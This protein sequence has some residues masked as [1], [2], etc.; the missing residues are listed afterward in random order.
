MELHLCKLIKGNRVVD[1]SVNANIH[2]WSGEEFPQ[3]KC[4]KNLHANY[5]KQ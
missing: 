3:Y 5:I 4:E 2:F 1:K